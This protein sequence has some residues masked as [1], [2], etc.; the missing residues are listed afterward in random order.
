MV[1]LVVGVA[2]AAGGIVLRGWVQATLTSDLRSRNERIV[3]FMADS[4]SKGRVPAELFASVNDLDGQLDQ[5][6]SADLFGR[7]TNAEQVLASTYFYLD[8]QGLSDLNFKVDDQGRLVLFGRQG[9]P[10]PTAARAI[11][12]TQDLPTQYGTLRLHAVSPVDQIDQSVSAL[13]LGLLISLPLLVA[14]AGLM[15]WFI[16]GRALAPVALMTSRVQEL[17]ANN[18][19]ARVPVPNTNDEIAQLG[20][21]LNEMLDRLQKSSVTQRQF[22][23]DASHELRSPVASIRAQLET[24]LQYPEDVDWPAVARIVLSE[25]DRLEHLVGNL[26]A[27]A[28]LEEGRL[29]RR[30]EVDLDDLVMEQ[31]RRMTAVRMDVSAVSAGRVWGNPDELTSVIRNLLDNAARYAASVI[32]VSVLEDGPWVTLTVADDGPG[33]PE[34][35]RLQVFERFA[36]LQEGRER[37]KG[38]TG[39]GLSLTKRIV[40]SHGGSIRVDSSDTGG[41]L[42]VVSLPATGAAG[43]P[44]Q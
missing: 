15:T 13:T 4:L 38:G 2:L 26:L 11:E 22:I 37:D 17:T 12:V 32:K 28:R 33:V 20:R 44:D 14:G 18:L 30:S 19:D 39:L 40:E 41:A 35:E 7:A 27:M 5:Q 29:G 3:S 10:R 25:D 34:G 23:S 16:T 43:W 1:L 6:T 24:A 8:G 36:R 9:P 31:T 42:F 21:M